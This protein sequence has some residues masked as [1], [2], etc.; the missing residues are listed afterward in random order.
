MPDSRQ[1]D[2]LVF[3]VHPDVAAG[4]RALAAAGLR[5]VTLSN[6]AVGVA[7]GLLGRAG[8]RERADRHRRGVR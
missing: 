1:A 8:V 3:D 5:L 4:V 6:G 7:E 2:A